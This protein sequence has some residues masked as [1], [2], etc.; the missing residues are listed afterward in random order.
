VVR[1]AGTAHKFGSDETRRHLSMSNSI[2][3]SEVEA[4][5]TKALGGA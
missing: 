3:E 5:L 4:E 2:P 1:V